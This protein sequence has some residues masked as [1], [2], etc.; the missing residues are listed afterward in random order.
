[1]ALVLLDNKDSF[2][3]NIVHLLK[4][5]GVTPVVV[6]S[7][8]VR[9]EEL[10]SFSHIIFSPGPGKPEQYPIMGQVL[11]RYKGEKKILGVCLGFQYIC[12]YF[13]AQ[14]YALPQ[15][16]HGQQHL[17]E[18]DNTDILYRSLANRLHVG[19]YHS[20]AIAATTLPA[21][22]VASAKSEQGVLMS[23]SHRSLP[24]YGMQYHPESFLTSEGKQIMAHFLS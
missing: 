16:C 19:L 11:D 7:A 20:W 3:Y 24:I 9:V 5:L 17:I 14:L 21:E 2:T 23:V 10:T 1:M 18:V 13:G 4:G 12:E 22:L 8:R 15:V 6:D